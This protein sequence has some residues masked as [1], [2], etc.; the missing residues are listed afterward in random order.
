M[1]DVA[2]IIKLYEEAKQAKA[3]ADAAEAALR[4]ERERLEALLPGYIRENTRASIYEVPVRMGLG[5]TLDLPTPRVRVIVPE[6]TFWLARYPAD[7]VRCAVEPVTRAFADEV[8]ATT[9]NALARSPEAKR[10]LTP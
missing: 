8:L 9:L 5:I 1:A 10:F 6:S 3:R 7:A 4:R 2:D